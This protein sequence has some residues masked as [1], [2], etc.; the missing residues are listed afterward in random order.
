[1]SF[2]DLGSIL[3]AR[4]TAATIGLKTTV[5]EAAKLMREKRTT[6]VCVMENDGK[7][8][9]GIFTSKDVVLRVIAAGLD[10][11]TC[12]VVRVMT[13]HPDCALPTLSIQ[14]ALRKMHGMFDRLDPL[15]SFRLTPLLSRTDGHYLNL[16]VVD[17]VGAL[18]GIVDVLKLTYTTLEQVSTPLVE[19]LSM[20]S[21]LL[22]LALARS[23]LCM[24]MPLE[25]PILREDLSGD[26]SSL[27][28]PMQEETTIPNRWF[29]ELAS[30]IPFTLLK[31]PSRLLNVLLTTDQRI[32]SILPDQNSSLEILLQSSTTTEL[33][34]WEDLDVLLELRV[35][36]ELPLRKL[37]TMEPISSNSS[38]LEDRLTDSKLA[39]TLTSSSPTLSPANSPLI[40]SSRLPLLPKIPLL[41]LLQSPILA[42]SNSLTATMMAIWS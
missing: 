32:A 22:T 24:P 6:A 4:T 15:K 26:D 7:K 23:T 42:T 30:A 31:H 28:L 34:M 14:D 35:S 18:V 21:Q 39:T 38:L 41:P 20:S 11:K 25:E 17:D 1:M 19:P 27:Q 12:S 16:P 9:A 8:I 2:P 3:D 37:S 29:P 13:P 36:V 33:R 5:R 10:A 40:P